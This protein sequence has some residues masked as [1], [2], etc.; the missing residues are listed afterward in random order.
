M[1]RKIEMRETVDYLYDVINRW[2]WFHIHH[3][4]IYNAIVK[5]IQQVETE[6]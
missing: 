6:L 3:K 4:K 1:K 2:K 5:L